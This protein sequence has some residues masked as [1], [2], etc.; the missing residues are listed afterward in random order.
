ML[1]AILTQL[2]APLEIADVV[3]PEV[4]QPGNVLVKIISSTICGAQLGEVDGSKGP[5]KFLPHLMGHEGFG[6]VLEIGPAVTKV[7]PQ[8]HVV[9][10][11]RKGAGIDAAT[12]KYKW[13]DK[14]VGA[15]PV[16][17]FCQLAVVSENRLTAVRADTPPEV[18]SLMGCAITTA[19]GLINNEA[20]LKIGQSIAVAGVGGVG[21]NVIQGAAMVSAYPI[22]AIDRVPDKLRRAKLMGATHTVL[23]PDIDLTWNYI[24]SKFEL[25]MGDKLLNV[26]VD[27]TGNTAM[28]DYGFCLSKKMIL[29]GQPKLDQAFVF[30]NARQHYTGKVLMDSQGGLTNP[31]EDIPRYLEL[32]HKGKLELDSLVTD[33]FSLSKINEAF[34]MVRTGRA[35]RVALEM[36]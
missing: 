4:L 7:R 19:L 8:D 11:W 3:L 27:C 6:I 15:G 10:H 18:G 13:G 23:A 16:H 14:F 12:P 17:T 35:G 2:N 28:I 34:D 22:I 31:N 26:F 25:I 9:M 33:R 20:Q 5:D 36:W 32:Y 21:L 24:K 29:V 30:V 1:A